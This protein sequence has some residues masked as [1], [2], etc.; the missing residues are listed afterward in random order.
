MKTSLLA[1]PKFLVPLVLVLWLMVALPL[2]V[3]QAEPISNDSACGST[4]SWSK[5]VWGMGDTPA[6]LTLFNNDP[7]NACYKVVGTLV[8]GEWWRDKPQDC[9][10]SSATTAYNTCSDSDMNW[11]VHLD[12]PTSV[13]V[14][15][16]Q[17][18]LLQ[19]WSQCKGGQ[20]D[21]SKWCNFLT[22]TIPQG[23]NYG[24]W[25]PTKYNWDPTDDQPQ[26]PNPCLD[27]DWGAQPITVSSCRGSNI[28]IAYTGA[29][30]IDNNH[31]WMEIHPVRKEV[32]TDSS[33]YHCNYVTDTQ[34]DSPTSNCD[35]AQDPAPSYQQPDA[36]STYA[37]VLDDADPERFYINSKGNWP[38]GS[39][40]Q[41]YSPEHT[42]RYHAP[43]TKS[44]YYAY[45]KSDIPTTGNYKVYAWWP[46]FSSN[47]SS[48]A[49]WIWT[50]NGWAKK[51][52]DQRTNGGKW[53]DLGAYQMPAGDDW[54]IEVDYGYYSAKT[55]NIVADAV[56]IQRQ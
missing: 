41:A 23:G 22:E 54:D 34:Q 12:D 48:T 9:D 27:K 6:H 24:S 46:A 18:K 45:Y 8:W 17:I 55:G 52:M 29:R 14:T 11:Y 5:G 44:G 19:R 1:Q 53:V 7:T 56:W 40:S 47:N 33:G 3:S 20:T 21:P 42:Y 43:T 30:A 28:H 38:T 32:W 16:T 39:N 2:S 51:P 35:E 49:F 31:G 13:Q 4:S 37:Q 50:T 10:R 25:N 36:S 15:P 26:L